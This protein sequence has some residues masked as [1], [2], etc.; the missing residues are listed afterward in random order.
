MYGRGDGSM[1]MVL[2]LASVFDRHFEDARG[3]RR[4]GFSV[5]AIRTSLQHEQVTPKA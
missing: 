2:A 5:G 4:A 3:S 1:P